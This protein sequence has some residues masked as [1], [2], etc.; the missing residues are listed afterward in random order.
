MELWHWSHEL[1]DAE[2]ELQ[3][4]VGYTA[5][6]LGRTTSSANVLNCRSITFRFRPP[7]AQR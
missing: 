1:V 2:L 3:H 4:D 5:D 7:D 6:V